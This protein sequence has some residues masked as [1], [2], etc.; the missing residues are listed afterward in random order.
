EHSRGGRLTVSDYQASGGIRDAMARTAG[1]A[2]APLSP[3][4]Q[5]VARQLFLRLVYVGDDGRE[6]RARLPLTDLPG[7]ARVAAAVLERFVEQ[8]PVTMDRDEAGITP[9]ALLGPWP[10]PRGRVP[11]NPGGTTGPPA[12]PPA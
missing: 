6:A 10:R 5:E 8:R 12:T 4:E 11:P 2:Y 3:G 1:H 9:Q 7:D